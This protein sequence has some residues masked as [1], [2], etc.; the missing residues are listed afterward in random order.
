MG[1]CI[2]NID[3]DF[4][5]Y[6]NLSSKKT[7]LFALLILLCF[8][9]SFKF[10]VFQKVMEIFRRFLSKHWFADLYKTTITTTTIQ[11]VKVK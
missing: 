10:E 1:K 6:C 3:L 4:L 11:C 8:S 9:K 5:S 2:N 7:I